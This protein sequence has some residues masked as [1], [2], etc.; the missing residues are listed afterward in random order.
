MEKSTLSKKE[1]NDL[2][3]ILRNIASFCKKNNINYFLVA[4]TL[5][6]SVRHKGFIP[7]DDDIDIG[8]VRSDYEKFLK[9]YPSDKNQEYFV[10]AL[11]ND[12]KYWL[13]FA[14]VRKKD[15]FILEEE[16][17]EKKVNKEIAI[18][19]FPFDTVPDNGYQNF[20]PIAFLIIQIRDAIFHKNLHIKPS[21]FITKILKIFPVKFLYWVQK[22]LMLKYQNKDTNHLICYCTPYKTSKEYIEKSAVLPVKNGEFEGEKFSIMNKPEVYLANIYGADYMQ[23]PPLEKR[24]THGILKVDIHKGEQDE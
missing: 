17:K 6:G 4:G 18:D 20:K 12:S 22:K 21:R 1:F 13:S 8:M 15:T 5:L 2:R 10:Q 24:V 14:K 11:E 16:V 9:L 23:L 3:E 19:V 7:W